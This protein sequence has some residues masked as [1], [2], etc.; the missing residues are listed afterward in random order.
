MAEKKL[1]EI[2]IGEGQIVEDAILLAQTRAKKAQLETEEK[3]LIASVATQAT[4]IR[5]TKLDT[6]EVVGLIRITSEQ[7]PIQVQF[8]VD[9]KKAAL[10]IDEGKTLDDLF[11]GARPL[12]F[13]KDQIITEIV[14]PEALIK[15]MK[16]AGHNPWDSLS[17]TVK[18]GQESVVARYPEAISS[19]VFMP[20][21]GFLATLHDIWHTLSAEAVGYVKTYVKEVI[22]PSVVVGSQGKGK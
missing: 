3:A 16:D 18:T 4:V 14:D 2:N 8:K 1:P 20:K 17:L 19:E 10:S 22:K 11:G 21:T 9:S 7:A 15:A 13:G 5:N 6:G 12:L